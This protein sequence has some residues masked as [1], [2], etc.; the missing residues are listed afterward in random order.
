MKG[1]ITAGRTFLAL[2]RQQFTPKRKIAMDRDNYEIKYP[3]LGITVI[4]LA[5]CAWIIKEINME[6]KRATE[7]WVARTPLAERERD[8]D[9]D[10]LRYRKTSFNVKE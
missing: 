9:V 8:P 3:A 10:V 7:Y 6:D 4:G 5:V 2:Q 1:L